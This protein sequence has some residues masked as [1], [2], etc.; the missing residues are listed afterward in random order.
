MGDFNTHSTCPYRSSDGDELLEILDD[1]KLVYPKFAHGASTHSKG[2][3]LGIA[4]CNNF[5]KKRCLEAVE[6]KI[7]ESEK[8]HLIVKMSIHCKNQ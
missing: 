2:G 7:D 4:V 1:N 3:M 6:R 5:V 8:F